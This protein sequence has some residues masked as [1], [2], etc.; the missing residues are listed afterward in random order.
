MIEFLILLLPVAAASGWWAA[1][2]SARKELDQ[3]ADPD[4]AYF[5]GLNYLLNEQPDKAIDVFI[6]LLD[7]DNET[8]ET[9][10]AL[11]NLFRRR[12]EVD[13]AIRIHQNLIARTGLSREQRALALL[14]LGQDYMK[15]GLFDRAESLF[16]E[17]VEME[18]HCIRALS[19]LQEIYQQEKDWERCLDVA[20]RLGKVSGKSHAVE[21]AHYYCEQA[22]EAL[23]RDETEQAWNLTGHALKADRACVRA[24]L[25][26]GDMQRAVNKLR[27]AIDTYKRV[28]IQ[29]AA[30]LPEM[31]PRIIDCYRQLGEQDELADYLET[32]YREQKDTRIMLAYADVLQERAGGEAAEQVVAEHVQQHDDL[33]GLGRY[34]ALKR[35]AA[36]TGSHQETLD[37]LQQQVTRVAEKQSPYQCNRCGFTARRMHWHCPGCKGWGTVRPVTADEL[38]MH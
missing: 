20:R 4:P 27:P 22:G 13:R 29:D 32:L 33:L 8:V 31:L 11:G 14:E 37:I 10:L 5:R 7:V 35:L 23:E 34:I 3:C 36:P 1:R 30:F 6:K 24:T 28:A 19:N 38:E 26:Q 17:L 18:L 2:R 16:S 12:G 25:I 21:I 15:A 9:H